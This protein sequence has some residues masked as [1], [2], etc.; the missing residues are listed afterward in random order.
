MADKMSVEA[1]ADAMFNIVKQYA[2]KKRYKA[3]DLT[4]EILSTYGDKVDKQDCKTAIRTLMDSGRCIYGYAGGSFI[5][6]PG[7]EGAAKG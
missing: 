2:G 1:I 4:K 6:L 5:A 7:T 3:G